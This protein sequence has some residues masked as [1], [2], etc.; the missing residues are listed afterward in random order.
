M[1]ALR[2]PLGVFFWAGCSNPLER[3]EHTLGEKQAHSVINERTNVRADKSE[4]ET[5][6][7]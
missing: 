4:L 2:Y 5:D 3:E 6:F 1:Q 7:L